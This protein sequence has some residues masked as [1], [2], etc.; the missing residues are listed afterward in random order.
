[1]VKLFT[2]AGKRYIYVS[3][4]VSVALSSSTFNALVFQA[5]AYQ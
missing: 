4:T 5:I 1:M 2:L 3:C